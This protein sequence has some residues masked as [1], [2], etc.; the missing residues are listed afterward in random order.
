MNLTIITGQPIE[1]FIAMYDDT[2]R[3]FVAADSNPTLNV[4]A[5]NGV[6]IT[7]G[8]ELVIANVL[9]NRG[10]Y[11]TYTPATLPAIGDNYSL[12]FNYTVSAVTYKVTYEGVAVADTSTIIGY[13]TGGQV[14]VTSP[15]V[16]AGLIETVEGVTYDGTSEAKLFWTVAK[17]YTGRTITLYAWRNT[18]SSDGTITKTMMKTATGAV[19]SSTRVEIASLVSTFDNAIEYS[20]CP[21]P[22][23][24]LRFSL[25]ATTGGADEE[26][27]RG[28]WIVYQ[29]ADS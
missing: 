24:T 7:P 14:T 22:S 16:A 1:F 15:V 13:L 21:E 8:A 27:D 10:Y 20:G 11:C 9:A 18:E 26:I 29:G 19:A 3:A 4:A 17:D 12:Q 23:E 28:E 2:T 6:S 25:I 5:K